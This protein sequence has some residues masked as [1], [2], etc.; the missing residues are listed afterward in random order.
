MFW[1]VAWAVAR[2]FWA[3]VWAVNKCSV[4]L[5]ERL[6]GCFGRLL[7]LLQGKIRLYGG[8]NRSYEI[9]FSD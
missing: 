8:L 6:L 7:G 1:A 4:W 9:L 5:L 3:F 2:V